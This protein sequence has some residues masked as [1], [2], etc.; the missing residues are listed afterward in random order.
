MARTLIWTETALQD[1]D[2]AAEYIARDPKF[3]AKAFVKEARQ[4]ARS[5]KRFA[6]R[7]RI[8]PELNEPE[9][10]EFFVRRYRL[11][12]KLE[13]TKTIYVVRFIHGARDF[14]TV[15]SQKTS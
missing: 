3:Y 5:L 13:G 2:E 10:R 9:I 7:G 1:L 15:W 12:Y 14:S 8:V 6:E 4:A 11:I